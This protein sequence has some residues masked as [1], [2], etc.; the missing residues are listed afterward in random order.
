MGVAMR[1]SAE[2]HFAARIVGINPGRIAALAWFLG[3]GLA[4]IAA[5]FLAL[6]QDR[7]E[8]FQ[9]VFTFLNLLAFLPCCLA[10]PLLA[11]THKISVLPL[12]AIFAMNP[13]VMPNAPAALL[14]SEYATSL[15][16]AAT[17]DLFPTRSTA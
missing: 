2:D 14:P 10:L 6:T 12:L 5:F 15:S 9:L 7:F 4:A 3:C 13:A 1:A 17:S 16:P 8:I 11:R